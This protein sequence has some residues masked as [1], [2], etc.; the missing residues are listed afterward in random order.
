MKKSFK[1]GIFLI[2]IILMAVSL[3]GCGNTIDDENKNSE[4]KIGYK[5]SDKQIEKLFKMKRIAGGYAVEKYIGEKDNVTIPIQYKGEK[6]NQ[7]ASEAFKD[8]DFL[9]KVD[10]SGTV[11]TIEV[12]AFYGCINLREIIFRDGIKD[13][14]SKAFSK[15]SIES[16][17]IPKTVENI[18]DYAF[19]DP[20]LEDNSKLKSIQ[21]NKGTKKIDSWS[22]KGA[23]IESIMIPSTI[24]SI[25]RGAFSNCKNLKSVTLHEGLEYI[26][27]E[28]FSNTIIESILIPRTVENIGGNAFMN[29]KNLSSVVLNEGLKK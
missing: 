9:E 28:A 29:C 26:G 8:V 4:N 21:F 20:Y 14:K 18:G 16:I 1:L 5:I 2:L 15:T 23:Q 19:A 10:I 27:N 3:F 17:T 24:K 11:E 13:I 6:I 7:I 12:E 25:G 22:F